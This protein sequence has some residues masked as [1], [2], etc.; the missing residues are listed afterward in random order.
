MDKKDLIELG[1]AYLGAILISID[2]C[3]GWF[4]TNTIINF[5]ENIVR[6]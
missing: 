3:C 1:K 5:M 6:F 2:A 4:V